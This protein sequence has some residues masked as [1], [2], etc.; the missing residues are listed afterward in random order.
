[1]I[2]HRTLSLLVVAGILIPP[3]LAEAVIVI[4]KGK[5]EPVRG[6]LVSADGTRVI[7]DVLQPDGTTRQRII[8]RVGIDEVLE[9][10]SAE[11][12]ES[13]R[14][15]KPQEYRDYAEELAGKT[16]DPDAQRTALRLYLIAAYLD[17]EKLGYSS[18]LGMV[19]LARTPAEERTFRALA[20]ILDRDH[21]PSVLKQ[22]RENATP[23]TGEGVKITDE[24]KKILRPWLRALREGRTNE[25][26]GIA[27][28]PA[29]QAA[30]PTLAAVLLPADLQGLRQGETLPSPVLAK[31]L[32]A[33]LL[34]DGET[35]PATAPPISRRKSGWAE[36]GTPQA[37]G[38]VP[39]LTL[40]G[41]TEF[42]PREC[43]FRAGKWGAAP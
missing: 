14:R 10:V 13:L 22:P 41:I 35:K 25:A 26:R 38:P 43:Q 23:T 24:Q 39:T 21:N 30:L 28:R 18:L 17:P 34:L 9:A 12:L 36:L 29:V 11:R 16:S 42:Q 4:E 2:S 31:V 8:P 3:A 32:A 20:Y 6:Y 7:V 15:D 5:E 19:A 33:E 37:P 40:E 27:S 1:M